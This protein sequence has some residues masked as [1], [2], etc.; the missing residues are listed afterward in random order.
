MVRRE[1]VEMLAS[2][3]GRRTS[4][5]PTYGAA[6]FERAFGGVYEPPPVLYRGMRQPVNEGGFRQPQSQYDGV[7]MAE[8]PALAS[9]YASRLDGGLAEGGAVYPLRARGRYVD[10]ETFSHIR[11]GAP[12]AAALRR[13]LQE[14]NYA[15][16]HD[17]ST[18]TWM[19]FDPDNISFA[20]GA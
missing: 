13:R 2:A 8:D 11:R 6:D 9:G 17:P 14:L 19:A 1:L 4:R 5:A 12:D 7:W 15:G 16:M 18:K 20:L 3:L 10:P